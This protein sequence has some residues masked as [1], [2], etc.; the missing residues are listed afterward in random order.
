LVTP[1]ELFGK[2]IKRQ[3]QRE[4]ENIVDKRHCTRPGNKPEILDMWQNLSENSRY[5]SF[6][7]DDLP[8]ARNSPRAAD[9]NHN[10][11]LIFSQGWQGPQARL[12]CTLDKAYKTQNSPKDGKDY[13]GLK[14]STDD[15]K[16]AL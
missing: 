12:S 9:Y 1:E 8:T 3:N 2:I 5:H 15:N 4:N 11:R 14:S 7:S 16:M 6:S 10:L 13:Q